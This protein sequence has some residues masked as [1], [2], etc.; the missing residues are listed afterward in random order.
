MVDME[1]DTVLEN[2]IIKGT[3]TFTP[4]PAE[5]ESEDEE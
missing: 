4:P 3:G 1:N 2:L 5:D